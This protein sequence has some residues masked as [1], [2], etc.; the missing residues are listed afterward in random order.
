[1]TLSLGFVLS[2]TLV[3]YFRFT[4]YVQFFFKNSKIWKTMHG[5]TF[6]MH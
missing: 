6:V 3:D 2:L 1:M 5:I 4:T